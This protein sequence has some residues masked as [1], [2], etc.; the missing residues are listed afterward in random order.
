MDKRILQ[1]LYEDYG[2]EILLYLYSLCRNWELA[3]DLAQE[4]FEK[5][6]LSLSERHTN[7]KAWLYV[8]ARNLCFNVM[9]KE[10][11]QISMEETWMEQMEAVDNILEPII[12]KEQNRM[13]YRALM[14]LPSP[15]REILQLQYFSGLSLKEIARILQ[16]TPENARVM[17]HRAK[18]ELRAKLEEAGYE[19]S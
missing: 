16:I 5:A 14:Q 2:R 17:S 13:L 4:T 12:K 3:E 8:V 18:K 11:R 15:R 7:V 1:K 19:I 10:K 9:K 6:L